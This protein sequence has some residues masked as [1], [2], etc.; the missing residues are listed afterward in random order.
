[1]HRQTSHTP[2]CLHDVQALVLER[3]LFVRERS[4]GARTH[5]MALS[6]SRLPASMRVAARAQPVAP[7]TQQI[8]SACLAFVLPEAFCSPAARPPRRATSQR[9][10]SLAPACPCDLA[11]LYTTLTY[12]IA[13]MTD[14]LIINTFA[15]LGIAAFVW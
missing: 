9:A 7:P 1:M 15:S 8:A 3:G 13:K 11:G 10:A 5:S 14:E 2:S 4:D 12:L 6:L